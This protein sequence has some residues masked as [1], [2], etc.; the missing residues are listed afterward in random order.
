M[1]DKIAGENLERLIKSEP[2]PLSQ[3]V[4]WV[5]FGMLAS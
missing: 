1:N 4:F 5:V 3:I 2:I